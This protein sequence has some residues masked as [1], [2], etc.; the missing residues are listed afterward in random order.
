[1]TQHKFDQIGKIRLAKKQDRIYRLIWFV[2]HYPIPVIAF[3]GLISGAILNWSYNEQTGHIVWYIT[4]IVGGVPIIAR[5]IRSILYKHFA[6]DIVAMLAIIVSIVLN[7]A[8][9]GVI[10][11]LMQS[12]GKALE[13]FAYRRATSS[14]DGLLSRSPKHAHRKINQILEEINASEIKV[15]DILVIK[16]GDLIP[17][18]GEL[19]SKQ[20][21]IDESSITGEPLSKTKLTGDQ[22]FSGS[23]NVGDSFE[24]KSTKKSDESQ[25]SKIVQ[26]VKKAQE[27]KAPLQRMADRYAVFF[28]P[29]TIVVSILGWLITNDFE[30]ILSVLVV[31]TPCSLI[32]ATPVALISGINKAAKEGIIAKTGSSIEEIAKTQ[33]VVFDKTGTIT[34]GSPDVERVISFNGISSDEILFKASILEQFSSH[35]IATAIVRK[36][37][38]KFEFLPLPRNFREIPGA[39]VEGYVDTDHIMV[40]ASSIFENWD[41]EIHTQTNAISEDHLNGKMISFVGVNGKISGA[42]LFADKIRPGVDTMIQKLRKKGIKKTIL[43]TGDISTNAKNIA[44]QSGID[45]YEANLIPEEKVLAIKKLRQ[46]YEKVIMVG[47]GINDAPALAAS[48][49]G[50]AMGSRGTAI[51]AEAAD[52]VLLVDDVSKVTTIIEIGKKT[53]SVAKQ[54]IFVGLGFSFFLMFIATLGYIPPSYGAMMQEVLD[55]AVIINALRAR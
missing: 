7:D 45:E 21:H 53:I 32:F 47:D 15:G 52:I 48:T 25:Y 18:D 5:T 50:V 20:A 46:D 23:I 38:E 22:V 54:S 24:I 10:I 14:L 2:I 42:I 8:F 51:S 30:T 41:T 4:L 29:I 35:P 13:D 33:V 17:A 37:L 6:L 16:P 27:E 39:G 26:L 44:Y 36:G 34:F 9:P 55:I 19:L 12:G 3:G 1:M 31:A 43:L 49:V 11:I 40:G 28:T